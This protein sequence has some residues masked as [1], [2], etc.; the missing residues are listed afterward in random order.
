MKKINEF[1]EKRSQKYGDKI[2]GVL[3]K[4]VPP[5]INTYLNDWMFKEINTILINENLR[6]LD[7]GCGYGRLAKQILKKYPKTTVFGIDIAKNYVDIFN[8]TLGPKNKAF[9]SDIRNLPFNNNYFDAIFMVTTLMYMQ[10]YNSQ[11]QTLN[12]M[13]RVLRK[14][15]S[16][17]IIERSQV[18]FN[19]FTLGG[20]IS[21]IRRE[22][23]SEIPAVSFAPDYLTKLISTRGGKVCNYHG[24]S[25]FTLL[26]PLIFLLSLVNTEIG[27]FVLKIIRIIDKKLQGYYSPSLYISYIGK[28]Q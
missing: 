23:H 17:V 9:Q 3:I 19:I 18:G 22:K 20:L 14:G 28:K 24:L 1:W 10:S 2:E 21:K 12:E 5:I 16:F 26:F 4:S 15:G 6:V 11:K 8:K 27:K 7:L 13:F 25:I